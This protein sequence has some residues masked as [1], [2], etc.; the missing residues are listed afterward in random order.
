MSLPTGLKIN[1]VDMPSPLPYEV[2]Y[3]SLDGNAGRSMDG[4]MKRD[5]IAEKCT[6][7]LSWGILTENEVKTILNAVSPDIGN[8][9]F[10]ATIHSP[11]DG[12][13]TKTFYV[14]GRKAP[15]LLKTNNE[16]FYNGL[17]FN[18]IER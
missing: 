16:T 13:I 11:S 8:I 6:V 15:V 1:G 2:S 12:E 4:K 18:I 17:S 3:E 14:G 7:T 9:F 5:W 10:Q